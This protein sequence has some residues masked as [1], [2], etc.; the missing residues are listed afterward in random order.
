M[1]PR[2][3]V[4]WLDMDAP[5]EEQQRTVLEHSYSYYPV[6]RGDFD[7]V[8]GMVRAKDV[9]KH[10]ARGQT[11]NLA[12]IMRPPLYIPESSSIAQAMEMFRTSKQ[13]VALVLDEHGG[14]EGLMNFNDIW[15][16]MVAD[17]G[18]P[19]AEA[20][21][22]ED[23]SWL[24]DGQLPTFRLEEIFP[25]L[26]LPPGEER[27]YATLAGFLLEHFAPTP[28]TGEHLEFGGLRFEVMDMDGVRID[29]VLVSAS[30]SL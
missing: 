6:Y 16:E 7:K 12:E 3:E 20:T 22:R 18:T 29:K 26:E 13:R 2:T 28:K 30:D 23:G 10:L 5:Y 11:F 17:M 14:I 19:E 1:I 25:D 8:H 9:L 24:L 27:R 4:V 15:G 21:Q